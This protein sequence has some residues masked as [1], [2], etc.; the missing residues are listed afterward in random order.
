MRMLWNSL[1]DWAIGLIPLT[2]EEFDVSFEVNSRN[3]RNVQEHFRRS[4][5]TTD[6]AAASH[7]LQLW[8]AGAGPRLLR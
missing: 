6:A 8:W 1:L 2:G 3:L 4:R 5:G 7:D